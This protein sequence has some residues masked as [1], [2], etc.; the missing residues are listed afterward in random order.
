MATMRILSFGKHS[1]FV[2][3]MV[4]IWVFLALPALSHAVPNEKDPLD[5]SVK[6]LRITPE[7]IRVYH[8]ALVDIATKAGGLDSGIRLNEAGREAVEY[9]FQGYQEAGLS[10]VRFEEFYPNRWWPEQ[11]DLAIIGG[12][13]KPDQKLK[14]FPLWS[15]E[16]A[17]NL[18]LEVVYVGYGTSGEFRGLDVKGKVV[19]V[20]MKRILH[21]I[22]S[23]NFTKALDT[24]KEKGAKA[25]IVAEAIVDAPT[26]DPIGKIGDI[27]GQ[28]GTEP[29]LFPVPAFSISKSEGQILKKR[30]EAGPTK[31]RMNLKYSLSP[32]AARNLV[33]EIPGNGKTNE[34]IIIGGHYDSW[35]DGAIDNL[36]SQ[37]SLL[38][39]AKYYSQIPQAR[40]NRT[41]LFVSLFG[42][43]Y[44]INTEMGHAA[45]VEKR[46][47]LQGRVTCFLNIDGSGSWGWEEKDDSGEILPTNADDKGGIFTTSWALSA[48]AHRAVYKY[49]K[50]PWGQYPLNSFVADLYGPISGAGWPCL[51]LISKHIYYHSPLDTLDRISPDQV[52]RRTLMNI[53]VIN[54]LLESPAGYLISADANPNRKSKEGESAKFDL[55][56]DKLP[57][58]PNPWTKGAPTDLSMNIVPP[59]PHVFSPVIT[60]VSYFKADAVETAENIRWDFGNVLG[61]VKP[62]KPHLVSGSMYFL[63]GTRRISMTVTDS[64][65]RSSSITREIT[66]SAG[67]YAFLY[68]IAYVVVALFGFWMIRLVWRRLKG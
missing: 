17:N 8:Q 51:L 7:S 33:G 38:A 23:F 4:G 59:K 10:K 2:K 50:G 18:E 43:E 35:F 56:P 61:L 13:G 19:L 66:V 20:D 57:Q 62:P 14:A 37:A 34:V 26:G 39:M 53:S 68:W 29:K 25:I 41:L 27:K 9:L 67:Q 21:F 55:T 46:S 52:Y 31:V 32:G 36:G 49:A 58:N 5:Q 24:A 12:S 1:I 65:G 28:K 22:P 15:C 47:D 6:E 45:F 40:R 44:G 42:H 63:P 48:M 54:D 11:Y 60:W 64:Q 3:L 30:V 16:G